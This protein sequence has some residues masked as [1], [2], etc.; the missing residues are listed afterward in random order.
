MVVLVV[1]FVVETERERERPCWRE[2]ETERERRGQRPLFVCSFLVAFAVPAPPATYG[3]L[4]SIFFGEVSGRHRQFVGLEHLF[5]NNY[6]EL[7][8]ATAGIIHDLVQEFARCVPV[9]RPF[10]AIFLIQQTVGPMR[11]G[12]WSK[13]NANAS[14]TFPL[15]SQR[16]LC[17]IAML[18][19][20]AQLD[21]CLAVCVCV[22]VVWYVLADVAV[23]Q[24]PSASQ[25][26]ASTTTPRR[27]SSSAESS[28]KT[29]HSSSNTDFVALLSR[30]SIQPIRAS[31][32]KEQQQE[33][34]HQQRLRQQQQEKDEREAQRQHYPPAPA[35]RVQTKPSAT[36]ATCPYTHVQIHRHTHHP[37]E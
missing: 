31:Q 22:R 34:E 28:K 12:C 6:L 8:Q 20:A 29:S 1:V 9:R 19:L 13:T 25:P 14:Q 15:G 26:A 3:R 4:C 35:P 11:C 2:E 23:L 5:N 10:L 32:R 27:S 21:V 7:K 30:T 24:H 17:C 37:R 18:S 33:Q 16:S 36:T